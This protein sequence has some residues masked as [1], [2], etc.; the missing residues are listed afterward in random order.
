MTHGEKKTPDKRVVRTKKAIRM[1]FSELFAEKDLNDITVKDLS[2]RANIN[3]KTFYNYYSGI[4]QVVEELERDLVGNFEIALDGLDLKEALENP[5]TIFDRID[6]IIL[7]D[8]EFYENFFTADENF[9][10]ISKMTSLIKERSKK[11]ICSQ[12]GL[13]EETADVA[14]EFVISGMV[15]AYQMW[16]RTGRRA[17]LASVSGIVGNLCANGLNGVV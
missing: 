7:A 12:I 2:D 17:P 14:L 13:T 15:S 8:P 6:A 4:Y 3:R 9:D 11:T 16:F 10:L 1:A 5:R